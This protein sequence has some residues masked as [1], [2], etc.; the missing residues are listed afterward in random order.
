[1]LYEY[2]CNVC[3]EYFDR[4]KSVELR[5]DVYCCGRKAFK[6]LS[7][8]NTHKDKAY[9]FTTEMFDGKP[10]EVRSKEQYRGLLKKNGIADASTKESYQQARTCAKNNEIT[11]KI[12]YQKRAKVIAQEFRRNNIVKEGVEVLTKLCKTRKEE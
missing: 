1:M 12:G 11:R 3:G 10:T 6:L 2:H 4:F 8:C 9:Y 5:N 7:L